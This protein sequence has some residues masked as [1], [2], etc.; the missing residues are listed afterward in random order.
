MAY[1]D[2]DWAH[3]FLDGRNARLGDVF[4]DV[5]TSAKNRG[6]LDRLMA[7]ITPSCVL[8]DVMVALQTNGRIGAGTRRV[9]P[10]QVSP[11]GC[12]QAG[13]PTA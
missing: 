4:G 7:T 13:S 11:I 6:A 2:A 8:L 12:S 9:L 3:D 1:P 10:S 5:S